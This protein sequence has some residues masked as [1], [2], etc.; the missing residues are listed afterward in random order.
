MTKILL[1]RKVKKVILQLE[2]RKITE[3]QHHYV[4]GIS[5]HNENI[6]KNV[7]NLEEATDFVVQNASAF[8]LTDK[9]EFE[10]GKYI[11]Q[12]TNTEKK[13]LVVS[14]MDIEKIKNAIFISS[15]QKTAKLN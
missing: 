11:S 7:K 14:Y 2:P 13:C 9:T 6:T 4:V 1:G 15:Y 8:G 12:T 3:D 10:N 5:S